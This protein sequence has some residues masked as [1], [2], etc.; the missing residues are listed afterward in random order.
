MMIKRKIWKSIGAIILLLMFHVDAMATDYNFPGVDITINQ[1]DGIAVVSLSTSGAI[2]ANAEWPNNLILL[3]WDR[4]SFIQFKS[5]NGASYNSDDWATI[6]RIINKA[7]LPETNTLALDFSEITIDD[8]LFSFQS[9]TKRNKITSVVMPNG[10]TTL[11]DGAFNGC[12]SLN[13]VGWSTAL[14]SIGATAFYNT[15]FTSI[16]IP[17]G[18]TSIGKQAFAFCGSLGSITFPATLQSVGEDVIMESPVYALYSRKSTPP[19]ALGDFSTSDSPEV[20]NTAYNWSIPKDEFDFY[21]H[22]ILYVEPRTEVFEAYSNA[23]YWQKFFIK[24]MVKIYLRPTDLQ[25]PQVSG[26]QQL[27]VPNPNVNEYDYNCIINTV[28]VRS[29]DPSKWYTIMLPFDVSYTLLQ[30]VFGE[31]TQVWGYSGVY[32]NTLCFD[33]PVT[34]AGEGMVA[35]TPYLIKPGVGK[36]EYEFNGLY[37]DY[38]QFDASPSPSLAVAGGQ[39]GTEQYTSTYQGTYTNQEIPTYAYYL[40]NNFF[41]YMPGENTTKGWKAYGGIV[42]VYDESNVEPGTNVSVFDLAVGHSG[43]ASVIESYQMETKASDQLLYNLAGQQVRQPKRGIY[44]RNGKKI[45][46]K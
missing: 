5:V 17:E 6:A 44:V 22:C 34:E 40:K 16:T 2:S 35:D 36:G 12:T 39:K 7:T 19:D 3:P 45:I 20:Y 10:L 25:R 11:A 37:V 41:Y 32:D 29:M 28:Y 15:G 21:S 8:N 31:D 4:V 13:N 24:G 43:D 23:P 1:D 42:Y 14:T 46:I 38:T 9:V 30:D 27:V 18:V 33:Q 26:V